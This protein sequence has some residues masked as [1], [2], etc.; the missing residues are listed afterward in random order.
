[1][2]KL[3]ILLALAFVMC[4]CCNQ[5]VT[6][7]GIVEG[8]EIN[9][10]VYSGQGTYVVTISKDFNAHWKYKAYLYTNEL[11]SIGDTIQVTRRNN[12]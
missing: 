3:I 12:P 7:C 1:M 8:V 4:G 10:G 11:Y 6:D 5:Y 9:N 2:K